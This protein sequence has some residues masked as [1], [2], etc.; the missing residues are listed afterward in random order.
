MDEKD[1][2]RDSK[3]RKENTSKSLIDKEL[4]LGRTRLPV[5]LVNGEWKADVQNLSMVRN[6]DFA[7]VMLCNVSKYFTIGFMNL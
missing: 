6:L 3:Q 7:W 2:D 4:S 5:R 1:W